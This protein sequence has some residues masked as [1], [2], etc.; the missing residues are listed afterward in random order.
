MAFGYNEQA[1]I[2]F[3]PMIEMAAVWNE[4][5]CASDLNEFNRRKE[6]FENSSLMQVGDLFPHPK[7]FPDDDLK[8]IYEG[9]YQKAYGVSY[10]EFKA[11]LGRNSL[12]FL[13]PEDKSY[14]KVV[15][16]FLDRVFSGNPFAPRWESLYRSSIDMGHTGG[17]LFNSSEG[18]WSLS[19]PDVINFINTYLSIVYLLGNETLLAHGVD[20]HSEGLINLFRQFAEAENACF[21][22]APFS[23]D[24]PTKHIIY[25]G[26]GVHI[27]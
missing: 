24:D 21:Q 6:A 5:N 18:A 22:Q 20:N 3:K 1:L 15:K 17:Y 12:Y 10:E 19:A 2:K 4:V 25:D 7:P 16:D 23:K 14:R 8:G 13:R 11:S 9:F 26:N 27:A